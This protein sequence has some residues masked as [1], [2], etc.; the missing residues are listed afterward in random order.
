[1]RGTIHANAYEA[2]MQNWKRRKVTAFIP[3]E[4]FDKSRR[5]VNILDIQD[6]RAEYSVVLAKLRL[7]KE[8]PDLLDQGEYLRLHFFVSY[9]LG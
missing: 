3:E 4:E 6:I 2:D 9:D 7:A 1:M 8:V 5:P